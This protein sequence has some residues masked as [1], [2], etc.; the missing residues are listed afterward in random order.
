MGT[1]SRAYRTPP[2]ELLCASTART[3]FARRT[4]CSRLPRLSCSRSARTPASALAAVTPVRLQDKLDSGADHGSTARWARASSEFEGRRSHVGHRSHLDAS[5]VSDVVLPL[6]NSASHRAHTRPTQYGCDCWLL[7]QCTLLLR[8][9]ADTYPGILTPGRRSVAMG[10]P[11]CAC[12]A[13]LPV[14]CLACFDAM[15]AFW[16][17]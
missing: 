17:Y 9:C 15:L 14:H 16:F 3:G 10:A 2:F 4:F 7:Q 13:C 12:S 1:G 11:A 5:Q 8:V 6:A